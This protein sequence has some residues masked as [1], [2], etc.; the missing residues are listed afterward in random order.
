[1]LLVE[2]V[3]LPSHGHEENEYTLVSNSEAG[4]SSSNL[5]ARVDSNG[6]NAAI[7]EAASRKAR[8]ITFGLVIH[9]LADGLALG[10]SSFSTSIEAHGHSHFHRALD[11]DLQTEGTIG[12]QL[13]SNQLTLI[14]FLALLIHKFPTA[15]ALSTSLLP[16][17]PS[18]R[19]RL[20]MGIFALA[21]PLGALL[22]FVLLGLS[23]TTFGSGD[24]VNNGK[25]W[26]GIALT[27][28]GGTFLYVATVL[29]PVR[30]EPIATLGNEGGSGGARS[31]NGHS[32]LGEGEVQQLGLKTRAAI[33]CLGMIIPVSVSAL[34]GHAHG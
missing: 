24:E 27:F 19:I 15:L 32:H 13:Q 16:L 14:V 7:T 1:M 21:T 3:I 22:S 30:S 2:Q 18:R 6:N 12:D 34:I 31:T 26:A 8:G 25:L 4:R 28:S 20:H 10:A 5:H 33:I 29:Q 9:S 17:I 23:H 11:P